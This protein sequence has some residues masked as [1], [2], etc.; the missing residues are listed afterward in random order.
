MEGDGVGE[1]KSREKRWERELEE[2][3]RKEGKKKSAFVGEEREIN[4]ETKGKRLTLTVSLP[5]LDQGQPS[6]TLCSEV[7]VIQ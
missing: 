2:T 4:Q 3:R 6:R 7:V 5:F 1:R